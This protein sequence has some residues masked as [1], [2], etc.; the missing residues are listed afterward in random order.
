MIGDSFSSITLLRICTHMMKKYPMMTK[1]INGGA[2][3]NTGSHLGA[4]A[5]HMLTMAINWKKKLNDF[6]SFKFFSVFPSPTQAAW[7]HSEASW[8]FLDQPCLS[9]LNNK[10]CKLLDKHATDYTT[11]CIILQFSYLK[12]MSTSSVVLLALDCRIINKW[13]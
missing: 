9:F 1:W 3:P 5:M 4:Y 12:D 2:L 11:Y 7:W 6:S 13:D 10:L 8:I